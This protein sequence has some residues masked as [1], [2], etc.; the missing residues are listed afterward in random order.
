M[1]RNILF[2]LEKPA[3]LSEIRNNPRESQLVQLYN[4]IIGICTA[5]SSTGI[6]TSESLFLPDKN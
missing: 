4:T 5:Y 6:N 3:L 2:S 1:S